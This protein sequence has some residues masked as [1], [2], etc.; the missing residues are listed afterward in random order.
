MAKNSKQ[1]KAKHAE[2]KAKRVSKAKKVIQKQKK[3]KKKVDKKSKQR[4]NVHVEGWAEYHYKHLKE[5]LSDNEKKTYDKFSQFKDAIVQNKYAEIVS[6]FY[7]YLRALKK[8][9]KE[10]VIFIRIED[11][12]HFEEFPRS[13]SKMWDD[14]KR[15]YNLMLKKETYQQYKNDFGSIKKKAEESEEDEKNGVK[16]EKQEQLKASEKEV[17]R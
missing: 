1:P 11:R 3:P 7:D 13:M 15:K 12:R 9:P 5:T 8:Y 14:F 4:S 2:N 6:T 17:K 10:K 16:D